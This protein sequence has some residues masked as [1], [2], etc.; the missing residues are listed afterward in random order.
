MNV[1]SRASRSGPHL[2]DAPACVDVPEPDARA[3]C[4]AVHYAHQNLVVHRDL[5]PSNILVTKEGIPKLLDFG[6]AKI[7]GPADAA[8][9]AGITAVLPVLTPDYAS[10]EQVLGESVSTASDVYSLGAVLYEIL[11]GRRAH[12]FQTGTPEEIRQVI[13]EREPVAPSEASGNRQLRG[14]LDNI[15]LMALRKEPDRRYQSV[16]QF[17]EDIRRHLESVPVVA[18]STYFFPEGRCAP[19]RIRCPI[20]A[21]SSFGVTKPRL[22][23]PP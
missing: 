4:G 20:V 12:R 22:L 17:S 2:G 18:T 1:G 21:A 7:L 14:D 16:E 6:I 15:V 5:K 19:V 3:V 11:T 9:N 10:P 23:L 13:C 8:G